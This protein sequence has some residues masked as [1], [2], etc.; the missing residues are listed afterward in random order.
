ME[1]TAA[2][3]RAVTCWACGGNA[4]P[5]GDLAPLAMWACPACGLAFQPEREDDPGALY[6]GDYFATYERGRPYASRGA[7]RRFEA[8]VRL[9]FVRRFVRAGQLLELGAAAG[10]FLTQARDSGFTVLGVEPSGDMARIARERSVEVVVARIEDVE[11][12]KGQ[13]DAVC[14]WHVLEHVPE[15]L[16]TVAR[17][18][19]A[20][21]PGGYAFFEVPNY[22]SVRARR[23]LAAWQHLDPLHHVAQYTPTAVR[24]LLERAG[25]RVLEVMT[26]PWAVYKRLP[27]KLLSYARQ[28]LILGRSTFGNHPSKHEL[29][30]V[31]AQRPD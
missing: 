26:V 18:R 10:H 23:D 12:P 7:A 1:P 14:G 4:V 11:L 2:T 27:R 17:L 13:F 9:A 21:R 22:A 28:S 25:L 6:G 15:P 16:P 31:V 19:Q 3:S 8:S 24:A 30:R 5:A 29:L 20:L